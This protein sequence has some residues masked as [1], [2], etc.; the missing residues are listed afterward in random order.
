RRKDGTLISVDVSASPITAEGRPALC[1]IMRDA[2]RRKALENKLLQNHSEAKQRAE[3]LAHHD[4]LT[5]L[6]NRASLKLH[7]KEA[8]TTAD[9]N[10]LALLLL[11]LDDFRSVNDTLG[12][13]VGD[14]VLLE[15]AQRLKQVVDGR[16]HIA[17]VGSDEFA[18]TLQ[19]IPDS[20]A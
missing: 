18:L 15:V 3:Y 1:Y 10:M 19:P 5:G 14:A 6:A 20:N 2:T 12:A 11:D 7:L 4:A 8:L 13:D 16:G 9:Q 17:R